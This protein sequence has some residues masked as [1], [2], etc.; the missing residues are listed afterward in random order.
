MHRGSTGFKAGYPLIYAALTLAIIVLVTIPSAITTQAAAQT[1][2]A[3]RIPPVPITLQLRWHHQFQ[4]AGYYA[5]KAQ[6]FY[7][8]AGLDVSIVAGAPDRQPLV[9]VLAGR[10]QFGTAN[11]ELLFEKLNG[12]PLVALASIFQ[13]SASVLLVRRDSR[14]SSPQDLVGRKVMSIGKEADIGLMAMLRNE[15]V[16]PDQVIFQESSY[17]IDDLVQGNTDAFN[18]YLTNE[19][20]IL[21][22]AGVP[23]IVINPATYGTDFYSDILFTSADLVRNH[24]DRVKRFRAASLR[25]WIYAMQNQEEI[26]DLILNKYKS[27]KTREHLQFES[28]ARV[29][30]HLWLH[31]F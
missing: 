7:R 17:D 21:K 13:H 2:E 5:A 4:F 20:Y 15:G 9:E 19:P 31:E 11:S 1:A 8:N 12:T 23:V 28:N 27:G 10:A 18:S 16:D 3:D 22:E 14:I 29:Q 6:G 30:P 25:G 24:P 26:V